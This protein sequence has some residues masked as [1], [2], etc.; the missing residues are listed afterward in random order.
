MAQLSEF[1]DFLEPQHRSG[2]PIIIGGDFNTISAGCRQLISPEVR[3]D[4]HTRASS[5]LVHENFSTPQAPR[6]ESLL[7]QNL[8]R[9]GGAFPKLR[10][11]FDKSRD[12]TLFL[13]LLGARLFPIKLDWVLV[14]DELDVVRTEVGSRSSQ[15]CSDHAWALVDCSV[16]RGA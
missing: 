10:D 7:S 8:S 3:D 13:P 4:A 15:R 12:G 16:R 9:R 6:F 1:L 2:N 5:A 11:E 14:S